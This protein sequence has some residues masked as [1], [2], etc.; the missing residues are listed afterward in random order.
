MHVC[1]E[2]CHLMIL[3]CFIC[4]LSKSIGFGSK[5]PVVLRGSI[6]ATLLQDFS[7]KVKDDNDVPSFNVASGFG[8]LIL[9]EPSGAF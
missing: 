8:F 7:V 3:V 6:E 5:P 9:L 1:K 4:K 2:M